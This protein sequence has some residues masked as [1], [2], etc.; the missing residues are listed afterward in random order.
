LRYLFQD[1]ELNTDR[2][3][4]RRAGKVVALEPQVFDLLACLIANR[5]RVVS[6][7]DLLTTVWQGRIV[8]ESAMSTRIN[9]AR[10][11]IADSGQ[12]QRAIKTVWGKG[13]RFIAEV[14]SEPGLALH[15]HLEAAGKPIINR[16]TITILPFTNISRHPTEVCLAAGF[17]EDLTSVLSRFP[18]LS[19]RAREVG[20]GRNQDIGAHPRVRYLLGGKVHK[21]ASRVRIYAHLVDVA[22]DAYVWAD[23]FDGE[24]NDI[25]ALEDQ[26]AEKVVG[27]IAPKLERLEIAHAK[28]TPDEILDARACTL[29]GMGCLYQWTREGVSDALRLF[30]RAIQIDPEFAPAYG[31]AAYCYIQR[32]SYGWYTNRAQE[33]AESAQFAQRAAEL[34]GDDALALTKAAHAISSFGD[35]DRAA[36]LIEQALLLNPSLSAAWYVSGWLRLYLGKPDT[37]IEEFA[38]AERL[39]PC[40]AL[41][42]KVHGGAAYGHFFVGRYDDAARSAEKAL[43]IRPHYQTAM[44][45][46]AATHMLAGRHVQAKKLITRMHRRNPGLRLSNLHDL[47]PLRRPEDYR[48][49]VDALQQA[50]LPE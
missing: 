12:E 16:P 8:S 17:V 1:C 26:L 49:W 27:A 21:S 40:D 20:T 44:R 34:A 15:S 29:R 10:S 46:A 13:F 24:L 45:A 2:R 4:L 25:F 47:L 39:S 6:K 23:H 5:E 42:F 18:W 37:A 14:Q 22:S 9:A 7:D 3:E 30:Q 33:V 48:K 50:G 43:R 41:I 11:A 19:V 38:R 28:H 35:V 32:K 36:I 31:M